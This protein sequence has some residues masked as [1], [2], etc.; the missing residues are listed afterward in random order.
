MKGGAVERKEGGRGGGKKVQGTHSLSQNTRNLLSYAYCT[1]GAQVDTW[2]TVFPTAFHPEM[3]H[4]F[5]SF[6][7]EDSHT[8]GKGTIDKFFPLLV[9]TTQ[10]FI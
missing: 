5:G 2:R 1:T 7:V 4:N 3:L 10:Q 9:L 8:I 6:N